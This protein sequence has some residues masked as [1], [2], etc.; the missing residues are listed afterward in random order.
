MVTRW[1]I[2][3]VKS[4]LNYKKCT[5][6]VTGCH[7][8]SLILHG[9][10]NL[11]HSYFIRIMHIYDQTGQY[12]NRKKAI[13]AIILFTA[14]LLLGR[15][16][17]LQIADPSYKDFARSN[18][19]RHVTD[20]PAR[21]L[22]YDRNGA[23]LVYNEVHYDLM[24]VPGQVVEIDT[25]LFCSLLGID[26]ATFES[27][28]LQARRHSRFRA[29]V[30]ERQISKNTFAAFQEKLFRF[31]GFFV[32]PRTL[33]RYSHPI[34]THTF[35]YVGEAGPN[36]IQNNPYY[37]PG[38]YIGISGLERAY[39]EE[40][41]GV[42]G[43][44]VYMVDV[45]NRNIGSFQDGRYDTLA[46]AG[47]NLYTTLDAELQIYG[48]RLMQN[49]RGS[50]VAIEPSTGEI[51]ALVSSPSYDPG[52][53]VGRQRTSNYRMLQNDTLKPLFNRALMAQY[54]PGSVFKLVSTLIALEE[55]VVT[56]EQRYGC[57]GIYHTS[58]ISIRCRSHPSPVDV[59]SG[60]QHSCN[61]YSSILF[62][63][64]INQP[65]YENIQQAFNRWREY[66]L[67]F[68]LGRHFGSDLSFELP[69][70]VATSDY[71]DRLYG[72]RGWRSQTILS[73]GIGQGELGVTPLQLANMTAAIA[74]RGFYF[75]PHIV[76]AIDTPD[77]PN[78]QFSLVNTID[79]QTEH[80]ETI[81]NAMH[82][83]VEDGTGRFS[84]I[85]EV[86]MAGKTG[87]VQNP[88]GENHSVFVAFAPVDDPRIAIS[89]IVENAGYGSVWAAPIASL[90]IEK[91]LTNEVN[92]TWFEQRVLDASFLTVNP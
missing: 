24:V 46:I 85:T 9:V 3:L 86:S 54:P 17:V 73:L 6:I 57:S 37:R 40:L 27:R 49:K 28:L 77:N 20:F 5:D 67:S 84:R 88:H 72:P 14:L 42:K 11:Y 53:L 34:A 10:Y 23:L 25:L 78:Q 4:G 32:Q 70:L 65:R 8:E 19:L 31:P 68:G 83:V 47:K 59:I 90:M 58:G 26:K 41:R 7:C 60:I 1:I 87:T 36:I 44:R 62:Q 92:R 89:V 51:L 56:P 12:A 80:F 33:R 43:R 79:I 81:V 22:I 74:N 64:T 18:Y 69:G 48:E 35:G 91:Y 13:G 21:G 45:L 75:T 63:N 29:S 15:L 76:K 66:V 39:E 55:G 82:M 50:I 71:Y 30:F 2:Q 61:T 52:L 16:F 38:D